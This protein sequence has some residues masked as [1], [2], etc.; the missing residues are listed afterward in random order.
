[1][2]NAIFT[3]NSKKA[4]LSWTDGKGHRDM[5]TARNYVY[6]WVLL[7]LAGAVV[8]APAQALPARP[9][10]SSA[11]SANVPARS[12][13]PQKKY[14]LKFQDT[15]I[16]LVLTAY[17][18]A[19]GRT[20]IK[21]PNVQ[22]NITL[23]SQGQDKLTLEEYLTAI[24]AALAMSNIAVVPMGKKFLKVVQINTARQE[25]LPLDL[26]M[27][28][29]PLPDTD[30]LIS[31][32]VVL[33]YLTIADVQP[34]IQGMLHGYGKMQGLERTNTILIT[35]TEANI[36][37][38]LEIL[39]YIDQPVS[40]RV[41]TRIY[42][43]S[44]AEA[45]KIASTL[46]TLIQ[47]SKT[48]KTQQAPPAVRRPTAP[49]GV[50]RARRS[51][52]P[53]QSPSVSMAAELAERGI[54]QG[55]VKIV[56]DERTN[57]LIVL[58]EPENFTFFDKIIKVLDRPV[59]P[60]ITVRVV[61]LEYADAEEISGILN[62]FIGA[63]TS[64]DRPAGAAT[65][66][67]DTTKT[68]QS[69]ALRD[70]I[71]RRANARTTKAPEGKSKIGQLSPNTKI[72]ADKRTNS[73]LLMGQKADLAALLDVISQLDVMLGQVLIEAVIIEVTLNNRVESG[74]SWLQ[75][76]VGIYNEET[77][78]PGGGISVR[79]PVAA[80]GGGWASAAGN[81]FLDGGS[82]DRSTSFESGALNYYLTLFDL[83]LDA[84]IRLAAG[85][86]DARVLSTPVI[87]TTD[88]TEA[89]II[90]GEERPIVTATTTD[91]GTA[92]RTSSYEYKNV[93][94]ELTVTPRINPQRFVVM[95]IKQTADNV[96]DTVQI[97]G[98][99]VPIITKREMT[100]E[101]AVQSRS[102]IVLGGLV[103]TQNRKG[104]VKIPILG[105]IPILGALF[106]SDTREDARTEL[107]V[108]ITPY[109]L[110]TP[111]E[112]RAE[113][114][115]IHSASVTSKTPWP[116]GWSD[117]P[118]ATPDPKEVAAREKAERKAAKKAEKERRRREKA[119]KK[120]PR[121]AP[122]VTVV[123]AQTESSMPVAS[124]SAELDVLS[125]LPPA[126]KKAVD[127]AIVD[128]EDAVPGEAAVIETPAPA[129]PVEE[130]QP[131]ADNGALPPATVEIED[132]FSPVPR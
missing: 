126:G 110:M 105:D 80:F 113:T 119:L 51:G 73:L 100:A 39:A 8:R 129:V 112:A 12:A 84:I 98:N 71:E 61:A 7:L 2:M 94:I 32:M 29:E 95:E 59:E 30:H 11:P 43:L 67:D 40:A 103:L 99:D 70:F 14:S 85:S 60:E 62:D 79:Q 128:I 102:T 42:E 45:G 25:G 83:N 50:I 74:I 56:A 55:E 64:E 1:M 121:V 127:E 49:P 120:Q 21:A 27:P 117:S 69:S 34:I 33:Q 18:E 19:T 97:D 53:A 3:W 37:R 54:V 118:L 66:G 24:D 122:V 123:P 115:R 72:L 131:S 106:R 91:T 5:N 52:Q 87:M 15:P 6:W 17:A 114:E 9:A 75:R 125:A 86:G 16:D 44:Y 23:R 65:A 10:S 48:E 77:K 76:S 38:I 28:E 63:A 111:E 20:I 132:I 108:L 92:N 101:V 4:R 36:Q 13:A 109:V 31:Q 47:Q 96:G 104:R 116:L 41:E 78:G 107:L 90:S 88:N 89:K 58:S 93:G 46:N 35:D 81:T 82:I 22:G 57:I 68:G 26:E 124:D 130:P